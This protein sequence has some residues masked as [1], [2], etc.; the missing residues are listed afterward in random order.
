MHLHVSCYFIDLNSLVNDIRLNTLTLKF[1]TISGTQILAHG[2][3]IL[4]QLPL[5]LFTLTL[6]G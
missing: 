3:L 1:F 6:K 5:H 4:S 2:L